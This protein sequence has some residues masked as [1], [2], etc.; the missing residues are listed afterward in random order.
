MTEGYMTIVMPEPLEF[1][2]GQEPMLPQPYRVRQI[3]KE[4]HD[5]FTLEL[6]PGQHD[7]PFVFVPGQFNMLYAFGVGECAI[8]ISGDPSHA[9][10]L[11]HTTRIVGNVTTALSHLKVGDMLGIRGPFGHGWDLAVAEGKDVVF[12]AGGIGLAPLRPAI[13]HVLTHREKYG[14]VV[15]LLGTRT[16]QDILFHQDLKKWRSRLDIEVLVT[17]DRAESVWQGNVGVVTALI[18]RAPFDRLNT[19]AMLCG[20]EIMM[21][22]TIAELIRRGVA[23]EQ[24]Y[25]TMERNMK[26]AIGFCGHCQLGGTFICRDGPVFRYDQIKFWFEQREV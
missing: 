22:F 24:I 12:V 15:I 14:K 16:P 11:M 20:P 6:E 19:V 21:Q 7:R 1:S 13:C 10:R 9:Q 25:L 17:V 8:S 4:T 23:P 5:T 2:R 26:C 18:R 3:R